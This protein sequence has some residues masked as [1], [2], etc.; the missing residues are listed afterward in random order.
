MTQIS[1]AVDNAALIQALTTA[2]AQLGDLKPI[3]ES[4][5]EYML[6]RTREGFDDET[7]PNGQKWAPL[8]AATIRDKQ[9]R[10]KGGTTRGRS[11]SRTN[12]RPSDILKDAYLLRDTIAYQATTASVAV[13]TPQGYGVHHQYGTRRMPARPFLGVNGDDV[14]EI[15]AIV[16]DA[17]RVL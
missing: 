5:G 11:R 13:G 14:R 9:R 1:I 17:L 8:A 4:I 3:M 12:A 6:T 10:Q 7:A 2:S 16:V 15:E